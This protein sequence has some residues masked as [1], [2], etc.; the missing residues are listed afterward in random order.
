[1]WSIALETQ[2]LPFGGAE[3][4][5]CRDLTEVTFFK[6]YLYLLSLS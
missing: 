3:C 2:S 4:L 5:P 1:M 6:N